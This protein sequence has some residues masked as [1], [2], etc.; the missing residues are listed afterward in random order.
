M[1]SA[2]LHSWNVNGLRSVAG[3]GFDAYVAAHAPDILCLQETKIGSELADSLALAAAFP[4]RVWH[5]ADK[6]GYSGTA[7]LSRVA[8]LAVLRDIDGDDTREGR[9]IS[10]EFA[11]VWV[12]CAYVPNAQRELTRLD[13]RLA[14][15][16]AFRA[17]LQKLAAVK[18]VFVCGDFNCAHAE[19]DLA[20]PKTNRR[21]AGFTDEERASF[22][23]LLD[24][25]YDDTFRAANPDARGAYSWWS[26]RP[27]VR[28]RNIGW[29][30]DYWLADRRLAGRWSDPAIH[31]AVSGSDHCPV[32]VR[33]ERAL[34][35]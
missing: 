8:P 27:G 31:A 5:H 3:K 11:G 4:H 2:L 28:E 1:S 22:S 19:A 26:Y 14:W 33:V 13:H 10:A 23:V 25:G 34:I 16:A 24:S 12:V 21:N 7:L 29:R 6:P 30:L 35:G 15:D 17:H 32:S 18:P 20:N 9:V